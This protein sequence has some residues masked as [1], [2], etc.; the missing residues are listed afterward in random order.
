MLNTSEGVESRHRNFSADRQSKKPRPSNASSGYSRCNAGSS[1]TKKYSWD[2]THLVQKNRFHSLCQ[3]LYN[4][5]EIV[6]QPFFII[7]TIDTIT[8]LFQ[9]QV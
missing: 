4:T 3:P 9:L 2:Y 6:T 7:V 1:S 5:R 8:T